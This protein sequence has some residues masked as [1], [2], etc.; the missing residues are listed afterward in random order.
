MFAGRNI[1]VIGAGLSGCSAAKFLTAAGAEVTV[2]D[3]KPINQWD[4]ALIEKLKTLGIKVEAGHH[5]LKSIRGADLIVVSP[6]VPMDAEPVAVALKE[7]IPLC[8]DFCLSASLWKGPIIGITGTNG[9]TTTTMLVYEM[10]KA[11]GI[12]SVCAGNIGTPLFD[13]FDQNSEECV[14]VLEVSSFQLDYCL[15]TPFAPMP[16]FSASAILNFAPD[17]LD[18]YSSM[19]DYK[20]SKAKIFNLLQQDGLALLPIA[21]NRDKDKWLSCPKDVN[22]A[23]FG[24]K[25]EGIEHGSFYDP[26]TKELWVNLKSSSPVSYPLQDCRLSGLHNFENIAAATPLATWLGAEPEAIQATIDS[27]KAPP[28]RFQYVGELNGIKFY[29]DS[30][31][32]N[33]AATCSAI[34]GLDAA[35]VLI[36]GGSS[37]GEDFSELANAVKASNLRAVVVMGEEASAI[38]A[39]LQDVI[40]VTHVKT[41]GN[42]L[43]AMQDAIAVAFKMAKSGDL[44]LLSPACASFDLYK[45]YAERGNMFKQ[46]VNALKG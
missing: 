9:K 40:P 32:T 18:R 27:F 45:N 23:L 5:S 37:K 25:E 38:K 16:Q 3:S 34:K 44:V 24:Q 4:S 28:H 26:L 35:G 41:N 6:G 8:G 15:P 31:A 21:F 30:K 10:L 46:A 20:E 13:L 12:E 43:K 14:A 33:V 36:A 1:L 39:S 2:S 42:G 7:E 19:D 29:N 22:V 17:H 11:S